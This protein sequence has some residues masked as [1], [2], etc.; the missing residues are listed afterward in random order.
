MALN[1]I[2]NNPYRLLGVFSN[3]PTKERLANH[4]RMKAFLKVGKS[5]SFPLDLPQYFSSINRTET[6]VVDAE[7]KLTLPRDQIAYA[8]FWFIKATALDDVAFNH[9]IAGEINKAEEI[10]QKREC[11]SSLQN[12]IMCA[13]VLDRYKEAISIAETLY[14]STQYVDQL[15]TNVVGTGGNFN[16]SELAFSFIDV[17]CEEIGANKLLS[18][19]ANTTWKDHI[20]DK[21]VKPVVNHIQ[22]AID[23]AQKSKEKGAAARYEA[24]K[25]LME[26]TKQLISQLENLLS[27][28]EMQYQTIVDKLGLEILQCGIDYYNDS[29][30]PNAAKN[31]MA[32][33]RYAKDIVVGQIAKDKCNKNVDI[34][35]KIIDNMPPLE[36]FAEDRAIHN[37][38]RRYCSLPDKISY[39]I[40]LLNNTKPLLQKIKEKLGRGNVY[41]L[42]ISTLVVSN[43]LSN[44]I[45]EVNQ[46]QSY[47]SALH[48]KG[49]DAR[50]L[51]IM[52]Q[53]GG[54]FD[55]LSE[56]KSNLIKSANEAWKATKLMDSFD[57]EDEFKSRYDKNRST[58]KGLCESL[59][60][61]TSTF[62]PT[63]TGD[64]NWG[65]IVA[66]IIG[67]IV[68]LC[69]IC[70]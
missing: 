61:S 53:L 26:D 69:C 6:S 1:I 39:A 52:E 56:L 23:K 45:E 19:T 8:Q 43:A 37:E 21:A 17:L 58:L 11:V 12:H 14:S 31:A 54:S 29:E 13:L 57:K 66:I 60:I 27:S 65:C 28:S 41:Y 55:K 5:V 24:G 20:K 36:V 10:W 2:T 70:N 22:D 49:I 9:L 64:T 30:E 42:R 40:E 50:T 47:I 16:I 35:Q 34:L 18:L 38:L 32:L 51:A 44:V 15:V 46:A 48:D 63:T 4:N 7:A 59:G 25:V 62:V 68:L 67:I 3:S 33:Q